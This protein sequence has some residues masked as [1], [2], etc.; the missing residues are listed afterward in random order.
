MKFPPNEVVRK[1][2]K[3]I[4]GWLGEFMQSEVEEVHYG[5]NTLPTDLKNSLQSSDFYDVIVDLRV[6]LLRSLVDNRE[7]NGN[8]IE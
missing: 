1:G 2:T 7:E 3:A 4:L 6:S 8:Y 5:L